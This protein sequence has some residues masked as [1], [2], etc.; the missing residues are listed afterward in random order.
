MGKLARARLHLIERRR[1][2]IAI[3]SKV[4]KS[5]IC[6]SERLAANPNPSHREMEVL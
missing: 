1:F 6:P 2:S 5:L 4:F 3:S